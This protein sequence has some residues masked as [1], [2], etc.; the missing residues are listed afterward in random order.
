M[1][2]IS[3]RKRKRCNASSV[4]YLR[5]IRIELNLMSQ[6]LKKTLFERQPIVMNSLG[7]EKN[8]TK[9]GNR[10]IV[11]V[12]RK[13]GIKSPGFKNY[14]KNPRMNFPSWSM[15]QQNFPSLSGNKTSGPISVKTDNPKRE[16]L[17]CWGCGEEHLLIDCPHRQHNN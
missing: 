6:R 14:K 16:P 9:D 11:H 8:L 13:R 3:R 12:F 15:H 4:D 17:K 1:Y 2:P 10:R 7:I 5:T